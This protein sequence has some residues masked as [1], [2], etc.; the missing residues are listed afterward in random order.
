MA[1]VKISD[2]DQAFFSEMEAAGHSTPLNKRPL[3]DVDMSPTGTFTISELSNLLD[4]KLMPIK[5]QLAGL[6]T[7]AVQSLQQQVVDLSK[8]NK[9]LKEKLLLQ[10]IFS[11]KDNIKIFGLDEQV[12]DECENRLLG[13]FK[14]YCK[15]FNDRTFTRVHRIGYKKNDQARPVLARFHHFKDKVLLQKHMR[16]ISSTYRLRIYDDTP[17]VIEKERKV[18]FPIFRAAEKLHVPGSNVPKPKLVNNKLHIA[19]KVYTSAN[20]HELPETLHPQYIYKPSRFGITA[21]FSNNSPLSHHYQ[22]P[23]HA[24]KSSICVRK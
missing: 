13:I 23:G 19:G 1:E 5:Q 8:E 17:Q 12:N 15:D 14:T 4:Q 3:Y 16:D 22:I 7:L 9:L 11:R 6:D 18:L 10:E 2:S 21:F 24:K 20:M